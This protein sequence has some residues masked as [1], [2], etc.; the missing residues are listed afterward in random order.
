[1]RLRPW[2]AQWPSPHLR[3]RFPTPRKLS[4]KE[5]R[6]LQELPAH[7]DALEAEQRTLN[8]RLASTELYTDEPQRVPEL[9][10]RHAQIDEELMQALER[11]EALG[12]R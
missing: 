4:F 9:Q 11:W 5:Q 1:M 8:D 10:A 7:I 2:P 12:S 3:L 6:E